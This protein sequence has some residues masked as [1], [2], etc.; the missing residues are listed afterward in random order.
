M[1]GHLNYDPQLHKMCMARVHHEYVDDQVKD[2]SIRRW[3]HGFTGVVGCRVSL[4][5]SSYNW[6]GTSKGEKNVEASDPGT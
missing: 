1:H 4:G 2:T 5:K 6:A 3:R